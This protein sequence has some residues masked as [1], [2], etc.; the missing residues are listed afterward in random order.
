MQIIKSI[1]RF[2][3][4][5]LGMRSLAEPGNKSVPHQLCVVGGAHL[6]FLWRIVTAGVPRMA[7]SSLD[8]APTLL[9][10]RILHR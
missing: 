5:L 1:N 3:R 6:Q 10:L 9:V 2:G 8:A 7:A 4:S